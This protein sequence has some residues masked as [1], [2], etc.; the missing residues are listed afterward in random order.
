MVLQVDE[1]QVGPDLG[2]QSH[3]VSD[4]LVLILPL[5]VTS[6]FVTQQQGS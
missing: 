4:V 1:L 5:L 6:L 3:Q 2:L